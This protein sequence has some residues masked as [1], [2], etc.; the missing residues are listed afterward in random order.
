MRMAA[1]TKTPYGKAIVFEVPERGLRLRID[2]Q[3]AAEC[4]VTVEDEAGRIGH[5]LDGCRLQS[6]DGRL[7]APITLGE[8]RTHPT[9]IRAGFELVTGDGRVLALRPTRK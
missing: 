3:D 4:R 1:E 9:L 6:R 2:P 8:L 5:G 7:S